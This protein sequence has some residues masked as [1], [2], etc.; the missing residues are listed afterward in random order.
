MSAVCAAH[1][2][3]LEASFPL[4]GMSG[5]PACAEPGLL[6]SLAIDRVG[7][8]EL[9][10]LWSGPVAAPDWVGHLGDGQELRLE[11]GSAGDRLFSYGE[12]ARFHLDPGETRLCC[13][14]VR[15]GLDWQRA[16]LTK[17]IP[18]VSVLR[19]YEALH[20]AALDTPAGAVALLAPSGT[21]KTTLALELLAHGCELLCDDVLTL[22]EG[23]EG[24]VAHPATGHMNLDPA[25]ARRASWDG[26]VVSRGMLGGEAWVSAR[27]VAGDARRLNAVF[28]LARR[29]SA[30]PRLRTLDPSP[31]H[32]VP[33]MLGVRADD[34]RRRERFSQYASLA[35]QAALFELS[36]GLEDSPAALARTI[37]SALD[38]APTLAAETA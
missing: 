33:Y 36:F 3:R 29:P 26:L 22:A 23:P 20:A 27:R 14:P 9:D 38:R 13:A 7:G 19:G 8:S 16:L 1:G 6:P 15:A 35:A 4:P 37:L 17:V 31:L 28:V 24:V 12:Q 34:A 5:V 25:S 2:L 10:A 32:L 21:G 11:R 18:T 30:L